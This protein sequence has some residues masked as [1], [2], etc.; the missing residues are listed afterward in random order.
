MKLINGRWMDDNGASIDHFNISSLIEIGKKVT[1][2]YGENITY[3]RI[4]LVCNID[5][6]SSSEESGLASLLEQQGMISK[7]AG[8]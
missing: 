2:L 1:A 8:Y 7:L 4:N 3:D 5:K 6:L